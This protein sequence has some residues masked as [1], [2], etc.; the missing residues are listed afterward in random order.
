MRYTK[1][2]QEGAPDQAKTA[3]LEQHFLAIAY[4]LDQV[5]QGVP[6]RDALAAEGLTGKLLKQI[7]GLNWKRRVDPE[8]W[9]G[10][11]P[12]DR[13]AAA[14]DARV[15]PVLRRM[16]ALLSACMEAAGLDRTPDLPGLGDAND[17]ANPGPA[18]ADDASARVEITERGT[19]TSI[20][21]APRRPGPTCARSCSPVPAPDPKNCSPSTSTA[22]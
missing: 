1:G 4:A 21:C 20:G 5:G 15:N 19:I 12:A 10:M 3:E 2:D 17:A 11:P 13:E 8:M 7:R 18:R 14:K 9:L 16:H 22:W 6:L